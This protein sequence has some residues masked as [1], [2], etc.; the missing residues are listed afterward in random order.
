MWVR[1]RVRVR[2]R[3]ARGMT[4][5]VAPRLATKRVTMMKTASSA[6]PR[7]VSASRSMI[8]Y[9]LGVGLGLGLG[10]GLEL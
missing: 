3:V 5:K 9:W 8:A 4:R 6:R 10:L 7:L 2:V 1:V